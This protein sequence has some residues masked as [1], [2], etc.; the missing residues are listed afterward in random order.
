MC[1]LITAIGQEIDPLGHYWP[2]PELGPSPFWTLSPSATTHFVPTGIIPS[3]RALEVAYHWRAHVKVPSV[4]MDSKQLQ[5][6]LD[7]GIR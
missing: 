1:W 2:V 3:T 6:E 5:V 7:R 4:T